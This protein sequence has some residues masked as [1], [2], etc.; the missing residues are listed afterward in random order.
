MRKVCLVVA[1]VVVCL[2]LTNVV[3]VDRTNMAV[4][5][6]DSIEA[7]TQMP[8]KVAA[9]FHRA[10]RDC[11]TEL[12]RWPWYSGVAPF[13]WL[14]TA[15][16]Y[17]GREHMNLSV[18]GRYTT[19]E[20]TGHLIAIREMVAANKMPLWYYKPLHYPSSWLSDADR[21]TICDWAKGQVAQNASR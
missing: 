4:G 9:I 11:H 15:D 10:C 3:R 1:A 12:T 20:R 14:T 17:S 7:Q 6:A 2:G 13:L 19:E 8:P 18:W 21:T 16:V 5:T